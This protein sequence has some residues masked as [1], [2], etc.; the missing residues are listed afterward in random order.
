MKKNISNMPDM[1]YRTIATHFLFWGVYFLYVWLP[2]GNINDKYW[3]YF[4]QA[5]CVVP[6]VMAGTYYTIYV[7]VERFLFSKK[8]LYFWLSLAASLV[9]FG[10]LRRATF[11]GVIY[12]MLHPDKVGEPLLYYPKIMMGAVQVHLIAS[13]GAMIHLIGKW[14][15]QQHISEKLKKEKVA[16]ELELL[17]SQVQPHF[18][19]NTLNNIYMLSMKGSPQ[20]SD[21]IY[22]LSALLSYMLYDSKQQFIDIDKEIDYIKN[23]I[24][25]EK[26]RYGSRLDI[27]LNVAK[28]IKNINIPPLLYLPLVENAFKHGARNAVQ[29]SWI[30][31]DI[32]LKKNTLTFKIENSI[33][34]S[35]G[36]NMG[37]G[38]GLGL[39]N[40]KRRLEIHYGTHFELKTMREDNTFLS[41]LKLDTKQANTEGVAIIKN[42]D[43]NMENTKRHEE[44]GMLL[45]SLMPVLKF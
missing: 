25:L 11:W 6:V 24:D 43:L 37:L 38:G 17:K 42:E 27:Q 41:V 14:K 8:P 9:V 5:C 13:V 31:I 39:E 22:R 36:H 20:T 21:M 4:I 1:N 2:E 16:A 15:E 34:E 28:S 3:E 35:E 23:Y 30:H 45:K 29:D 32:S 10:I 7:T 18:I 33:S 40:L 12:P 44:V 19:F 26:I